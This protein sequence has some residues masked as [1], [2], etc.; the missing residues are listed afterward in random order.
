MAADPTPSTDGAHN[1]MMAVIFMTKV[2]SFVFFKVSGRLLEWGR[3]GCLD[4][5]EP[6]GMRGVV[7][8]VG[9]WLS[10]AVTAHCRWRARRGHAIPK[11]KRSSS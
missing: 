7:A 9:V 8:T 11:S 2:E 4:T 3:K 1:P 6:T 5:E 10:D